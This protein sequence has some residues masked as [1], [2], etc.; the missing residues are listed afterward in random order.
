MH[1]GQFLEGKVASL[2][3]T[4]FRARIESIPARLYRFSLSIGV[5]VQVVFA[6]LLGE[7]ALFTP[8]YL[9]SLHDL[10]FSLIDEPVHLLP[11]LGLVDVV[12]VA[13]RGEVPLFDHLYLF[14]L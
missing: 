11:Q 13:L 1:W 14:L 2:G 4:S 9:K 12:I 10:G 6:G 3:F 5:I 7:I 8:G